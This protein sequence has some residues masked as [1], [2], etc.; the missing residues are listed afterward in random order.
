MNK[1][2]QPHEAHIPYLLQVNYY[3]IVLIA[4]FNFHGLK[5]ALFRKIAGL[6]QNIN[7]TSVQMLSVHFLSDLGKYVNK[8]CNLFT[9]EAPRSYKKSF[10]NVRAFQD[11]IGIWKCLF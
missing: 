5:L 7:R 11:R 10:R 4:L 1:V 9:H 8:L 2:F 3:L 6:Q